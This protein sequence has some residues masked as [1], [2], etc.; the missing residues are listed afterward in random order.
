MPKKTITP[1]TIDQIEQ[2]LKDNGAPAVVLRSDVGK[3]SC[4]FLHPLTV[5]NHDS[6]GTGPKE[7]VIY[8]EK[9]QAVGYP[10]RALAE[11]M[12]GRGFVIE[13]RQEVAA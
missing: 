2:F 8:G 4:L 7:R 13:Q 3:Y 6:L 12:A 9:R 5:R 1:Q 10:I 11:Y